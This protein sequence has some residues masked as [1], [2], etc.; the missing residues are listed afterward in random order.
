MHRFGL[1]IGYFKPSKLE[2][3]A[4]VTELARRHPEITL[5]DEEI[6]SRAHAWEMRNGGISCRTAQQFVNH[7]LGNTMDVSNG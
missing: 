3:E 5:S 7:L 6:I 4:I 2:F 1:T